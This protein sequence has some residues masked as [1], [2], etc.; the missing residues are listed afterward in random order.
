[1][2]FRL[3]L[4]S[5]ADLGGK[6][7]ALLLREDARS[8]L[9]RAL[10]AGTLTLADAFTF[11][12]SLYFRGKRAYARAFAQPPPGVEGAWVITTD[13]GLVPLETPVG[14]AMLREMAAGTI[15]P[16]DS[17]YRGP[18]V[19]S[20]ARLREHAG[21]GCEAVLLGSLA[22]DK[23]LDPL[24][25]VWGGALSVPEAFI[26]RGDMSRGGLMLR[27]VEE[28]RELAYVGAAGAERSGTRP[29]RLAPRPRHT[30]GRG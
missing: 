10:H 3:F 21:P 27:A 26:G 29:P 16:A 11:T 6:R 20:A 2:A 24:L 14:P 25:E 8:D 22:T 19:A 4:L 13:R 9:A 30:R 12:S 23:Y 15:D 18:L 7:A 1:M 17:R 28:R 5:P